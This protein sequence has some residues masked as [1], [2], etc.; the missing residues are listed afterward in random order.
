MHLAKR[1][2]DAY[3]RVVM[4]LALDIPERKTIIRAL[5]DPPAGLEELRDVLL[6]EHV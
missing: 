5:D 6:C 2:E 3:G 4:I 1:L